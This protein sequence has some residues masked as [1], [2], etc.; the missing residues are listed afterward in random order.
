MGPIGVTAV[1]MKNPFYVTGTNQIIAGIVIQIGNFF[2][3][4]TT[5]RPANFLLPGSIRV[6]LVRLGSFVTIV[7]QD[8]PQKG[9]G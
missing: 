8:I 2:E 6:P 3:A 7:V 1:A 9:V 4:E 5:P